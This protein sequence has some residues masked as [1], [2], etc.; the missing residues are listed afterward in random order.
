MSRN[1]IGAAAIALTL[2]CA[3][4]YPVLAGNAAATP[5]GPPVAGFTAGNAAPMAGVKRVAIAQVLVSF[6]TSVGDTVSTASRTA[7]YAKYGLGALLRHDK[8]SETGFMRL[9]LD[10]AL[11]RQIAG[12]VY[13]GLQADLA[14]AGFE[15]VPE[16][17]VLG[18]A[19]YQSLLKEA[20]YTNPSRYFN[21]DG[22]V[23]LAAPDM[24]RPYMP[25]ALEQ[26][27]FFEN[28]QRKSYISGWIRNIPMSGGSSTDGGPKFTLASSA[29]KGPDLEAK[30]A[31][32]LN[33]AVVKA[34]YIVTLG[35][36][37][38]SVSHDYVWAEKGADALGRDTSTNT[39]TTTTSGTASAALGLRGGQSR[40]AFRLAGGKSQKAAK[41]EPYQ[42]PRDGDV[43]LTI[44]RAVPGLAGYFDLQPGGK[45]E[46]V[47]TLRDKE[48]FATD[49]A[50]MI[51]TE[52]KKMLDLV[53][54]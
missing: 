26:G 54:R 38:L 15:V 42:L 31:Q 17:D 33:A 10:P 23:L 34:N 6:Q 9:E 30:M 39:V 5:S 48:R 32:E 40:L 20:G 1:A 51:G 37:D 24:L 53:R 18:N 44:D 41:G 11:A 43:V 46:M 25:Y 8:T 52:Q 35:R 7:D 3:A 21:M 45:L 14:A 16:A 2:L 47:A 36:V 22:D 49:S 13:A 4:P 12:A 27:D 19:S 50:A 29:W 28:G